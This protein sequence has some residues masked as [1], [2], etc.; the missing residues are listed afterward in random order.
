MKIISS[1]I[2]LDSRRAYLQH[3]E[4]RESLRIVSGNNS[5]SYDS[6]ESSTVFEGSRE[7][8]IGRL[9]QD[10]VDLSERLNNR[11]GRGRGPLDEPPRGPQNGGPGVIGG[12]ESVQM[13]EILAGEDIKLTLTKTIL[14]KLLKTE[15]KVSRIDLFKDTPAGAEVATPQG[16][17]PQAPRQDNFGLSYER[18]SLSYEAEQTEF[19]AVGKVKTADGKEIDFAVALDMSRESLREESVSLRMGVLQDPLVVNFGGNA[20]ELTDQKFEFDLDSDGEAENVSFLKSNSGFLAF[21]RNGDG[22]INDGS[23][24]FGPTTGDGF[25]E[26]AE[27]DQDGNNFIDEGDAVYNSLGIYNKNASGADVLTRL[28]D[29]NVGAIYLDRASTEFSLN[30]EAADEQLGQV[31]SSSVYIGEDGTVGTVQ[32]VDLAV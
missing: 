22:V 7:L 11:L 19:T 30:N 26:L 17:A 8:T 1:S 2:A 4:S 28:S 9:A 21:D 16:G 12:G 15:I 3:Q 20:A 24:L 25:A 31:R 29:T 13:D 6:F 23:E 10:T 32:Q 27:Y 5:L 18:S 14:E